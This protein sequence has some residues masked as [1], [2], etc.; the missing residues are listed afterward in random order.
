MTTT[1]SPSLV[2][3]R[4]EQSLEGCQEVEG[5]NPGRLQRGQYCCGRGS[6]TLWLCISDPKQRVLK[7]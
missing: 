6:T 3:A 4:E 5:S 1:R 7:P 2:V